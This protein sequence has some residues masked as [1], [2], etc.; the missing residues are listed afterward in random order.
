MTN[1]DNAI[2][3]CL[4]SA[5]KI[6][7]LKMSN[8]VG[9]CHCSICRKWTGGPFLAVDCGNSVQLT[10]DENISTFNSSEWAERGFCNKCGT[11]LFYKLKQTGQYIMS[12]G[13]F[14]DSADLNFD[15]QIFI[16]EKPAYYDFSNNTKNMTGEQVFAQF[17]SST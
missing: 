11:H 9:A 14:E 1:V 2:G 6:K 10:G 12:A 3:S 17:T 8:S 4:C 13:I 16:D 7:V 15:H 5:V